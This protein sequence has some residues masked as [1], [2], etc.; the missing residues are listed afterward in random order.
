M[1]YVLKQSE[2]FTFEV[3]LDPYINLFLTGRRNDPSWRDNDLCMRVYWSK[4][5]SGKQVE[6]LRSRNS[7][8]TY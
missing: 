6:P 1:H 2:G 7:S 3:F 8:G 5:S 4:S